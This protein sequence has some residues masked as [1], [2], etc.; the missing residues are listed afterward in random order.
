MKKTDLVPVIFPR[1]IKI[2]VGALQN[3][4]RKTSEPVPF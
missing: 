3:E 2:Q 1:P 4:A